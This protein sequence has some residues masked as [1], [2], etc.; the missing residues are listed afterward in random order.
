MFVWCAILCYF[1]CVL[2]CCCKLASLLT[3]KLATLR[4]CKLAN[5]QAYKLADIKNV[6]LKKTAFK[7]KQKENQTVSA[8]NFQNS[9]CK[10]VMFLIFQNDKLLK[11]NVY[12]PRQMQIWRSCLP[13]CQPQVLDDVSDFESDGERYDQPPPH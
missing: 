5:L 11:L 10:H 8:F 12:T 4:T 6:C 9:K 13:M 3:R 1:D 7:S 2:M